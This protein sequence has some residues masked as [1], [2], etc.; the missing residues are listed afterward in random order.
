MNRSIANTFNLTPSS[1]SY[2][3]KNG[4]GEISWDL[5]TKTVTL[6][7]TVFIDGNARVDI[8]GA[9]KYQGVGSLYLAGSFVVKGTNFC[10]VVSGTTCDWSLPGSGHWD[11]QNNFI[12]VVAGVVGGGGQSETPA[13]DV[14]VE[15]SSAG[16]QGAVTASQR[17]DV[18]TNSSFQGPLVESAMTLGQSLTTYPFGTLSYVPTATPGNP[19]KSV[20][21]G[22]PGFSG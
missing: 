14:S 2:S 10:A 16:F 6:K 21:L 22:T 11:V 12:D 18:S 19:I 1:G 3:C 9:V 7:G 20:I 13:S 15:L 4:F 5:A 8:G 17:V